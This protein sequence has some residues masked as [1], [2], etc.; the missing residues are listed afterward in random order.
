MSENVELTLADIPGLGPVRRQA[1]AEAGIQDLQA[2]LRTKVAELAEIRGIGLWQARRIREF[3]RHR[4]LIL[5]E[6]EDGSLTV[7]GARSPADVEAMAQAI[8]AMEETAAREA[9]VEEEVQ[10]LVHALEEV[11]SGML[12]LPDGT[13][14]ADGT[15]PAAE[16][17]GQDEAPEEAPDEDE[18]ERPSAGA[19]E[20]EEDEDEEEDEEVHWDEE[21]QSQRERLPETALTLMEAIRQAAVAR[22]LTRQITRL[23]IT[24]GEFAS[25]ERELTPRQQ[26]RASEALA[27]VDQALQRAL[28]K[29]AFKPSEQKDL[30][31]RVR[32]RRKELERLLEAS[33]G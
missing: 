18:E 32:R 16:A 20:E 17:P 5:S 15:T 31:D 19:S 6:E 25:S 8:S 23:L 33:Q 4:G 1:L 14:A 7:A 12:V 11:R 28:E 27:Q 21:I 13:P 26:Q 22:Q 3:L 24:T 2:L 29:R 9:E 10:V 30:A